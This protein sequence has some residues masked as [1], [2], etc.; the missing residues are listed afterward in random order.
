[1]NFSSADSFVFNGQWFHSVLSFDI[2]L[3][4]QWWLNTLV[5][6]KNSLMLLLVSMLPTRRSMGSWKICICSLC[7]IDELSFLSISNFSFLLYLPVKYTVSQN[8]MEQCSSS[9]Y[10]FHFRHLP[11][12]GIIKKAIYSQILAN[13]ICF[14]R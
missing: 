1:M 4:E 6:N 11:F 5:I 3:G 7:T 14:S 13:S 8:F 2:Y 12:D 9:S 10:S